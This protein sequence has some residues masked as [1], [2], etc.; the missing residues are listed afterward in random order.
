LGGG[1]VY[2]VSGLTPGVEPGA[3][4]LR[5]AAAATSAI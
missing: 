1:I 2:F 3:P 4:L 5:A